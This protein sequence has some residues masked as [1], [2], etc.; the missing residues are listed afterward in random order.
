M[1][2]LKRV[3]LGT[4]KQRIGNTNRGVVW[5]LQQCEKYGVLEIGADENYVIKDDGTWHKIS[6]DGGHCY[7]TWDEAKDF[8]RSIGRKLERN[9]LP[10]PLH[11][12]HIEEIKRMKADAP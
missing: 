9:K 7:T 8:M 1:K 6:N 3:R 2:P 11:K 4:K 10:Y 5:Y 12:R